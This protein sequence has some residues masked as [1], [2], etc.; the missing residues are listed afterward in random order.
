MMIQKKK[1]AVCEVMARRR[2]F[3]LD[4]VDTDKFLDLPLSTQAL[5][6]HLGMRS[7]DDGFVGSPKKIAKILG[8]TDES[9]KE[10]EKQGYVTCFDSGVLYV[11][12]FKK[13]NI[14][15]SDRYKPTIY[16][17]ELEAINKMTNE[18]L[19]EYGVLKEAGYLYVLFSA[20]NICKIGISQ[21][22][23]V[24]ITSIKNHEK[25]DILKSYVTE[26]C[27]NSKELES[28]AHKHFS[29]RRIRCEWFDISFKE[30]TEYVKQLFNEKSV[31]VEK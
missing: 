16:I 9:L 25:S 11:N 23:T 29:N 4:I 14:N 24:R 26:A 31:K 6:F 22:P 21:N 12:H 8:A 3:S 30:A 7:D 2:M 28:L 18:V 15:K 10:L 17:K 19:S 1:G 13:M 5:Y 27:Y 20:K